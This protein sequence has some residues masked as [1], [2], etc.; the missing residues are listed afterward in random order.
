MEVVIFCIALTAIMCVCLVAM[1]YVV[2]REVN[3]DVIDKGMDERQHVLDSSDLSDVQR[4]SSDR[5]GDNGC[6][7]RMDAEQAKIALEVMRMSVKYSDT[8]RNAIDYAVM[9]IDIAHKLSQY[10]KRDK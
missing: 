6:V 2:G 1:G 7:E 8:E 10:W 4:G 3:D 5:S 9:C